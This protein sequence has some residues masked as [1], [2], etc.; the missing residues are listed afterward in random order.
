MVCVCDIA[1]FV[2]KNFIIFE[3]FRSQS[4]QVRERVSEQLDSSKNEKTTRTVP[5]MKSPCVCV[6]FVNIYT[7]V[8]GHSIMC[9]ILYHVGYYKT[10]ICYKK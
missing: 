2:I 4:E 3:R 5:R 7:S 10:T 6:H 9:E 8:I 1:I